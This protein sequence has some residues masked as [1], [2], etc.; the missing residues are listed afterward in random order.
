MK[1]TL[2]SEIENLMA[3]TGLSAD[4]VGFLVARNARL[5]ERLRAGRRVWP[6][7]EMSIRIE[8]SRLREKR[9]L[10]TGDAAR[11]AS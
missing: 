4:R 5:V 1:N 6:E 2:L 11:S 7:T 10:E 8:I 9:G 3:E